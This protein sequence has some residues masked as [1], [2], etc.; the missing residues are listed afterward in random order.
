MSDDANV[1]KEFVVELGWK[2]DATQQRRV[3][4][5][6]ASVTKGVT[7]MA[8]AVAAAEVALVGIAQRVARSFEALAY[9]SSRV[10]ASAKNI[11]TFRYAISQLGGTA[12]GAM[13]S[14]EAFSRKLRESPGQEAMLKGWGVRTRDASGKLRDST[15]LMKEFLHSR[16]FLAMP[17]FTRLQ[18]AE[19]MGIDERTYRAMLGDVEKFTA[20]YRDKMRKAGL[21]PDAAA[22]NAKKFQQAWRSML[23]SIEVIVDRIATTHGERIAK[24]LDK[25]TA[26]VDKHGDR[27]ARGFESIIALILRAADAIGRFVS[28]FVE[29]ISQAD[30]VVKKLTGIEGA[31]EAIAIVLLA[32][33]IPGVSTLTALLTGLVGGAAWRSFVAVLSALG[34]GGGALAM[35]GAALGFGVGMAPGSAGAGE[36]EFERQENLKRD[37]DHYKRQQQGGGGSLWER[38]KR[39]WGDHAPAWAG[40]N[41]S[42]SKSL[43]ANQS[44]AYDA[45]IKDGLSPNAARALVANMTGEALHKPGD[46]H[47]DVRHMSQGIVQ[48]DPQRAEAIRKQFGKYPKDMSVA[49][50]TRAAIWEIRN[51]KRFAATKEALEG[52]D[53]E[54]MVRALVKNYENPRDHGS[55]IAQRR[56]YYRALANIGA[57]RANPT[58]FVGSANA[59]PVPAGP[60]G[61]GNSFIHSVAHGHTLHAKTTIN[62][63]AAGDP[64]ATAR[65]VAGMQK[66]VHADTIRNMQGAAH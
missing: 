26:F 45:A 20:E 60:L 46:H 28:S 14:L 42:K 38:G 34:M 17:E 1:L 58:G 61:G 49:E 43:S 21:D 40:G 23:S 29:F 11:A 64:G 27:I 30:P 53:P 22:E 10:N 63:N 19:S 7:V 56:A 8:T 52:D 48:W 36:N 2:S 31:F 25:L 55:A 18:L 15:E 39:W 6:I 51:H 65:A 5:A 4:D 66:R 13:A 9:A 37:P 47:W 3:T 41:A 33:L 62:V 54:Q 35:G 50:Q 12:E 59:A 24:L 16:K 32:R 57:R 44:E